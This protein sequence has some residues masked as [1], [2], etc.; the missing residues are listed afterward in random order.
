M[1]THAYIPANVGVPAL[2]RKTMEDDKRIDDSSILGDGGGTGE[3]SGSDSGANFGDEIDSEHT[4][5]EENV[6][7]GDSGQDSRGDGEAQGLQGRAISTLPGGCNVFYGGYI[8]NYNGST[9]RRYYFDSYGRLILSQT[10]TRVNTPSG[11]SCL[12]EMPA[13]HSMDMGI[14]V[15]EAAAAIAIWL[16]VKFVVGRIIK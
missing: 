4:T 8:D 5:G 6:D 9:R 7:E 3:A 15:A 14:V 12:T 1:G 2:I 11:V 10:T 13:S 16:A